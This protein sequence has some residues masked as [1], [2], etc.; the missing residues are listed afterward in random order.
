MSVCK[1]V[2]D[3]VDLV[4]IGRKRFCQCTAACANGFAFPKI[5]CR[6]RYPVASYACGCERGTCAHS[7]PLEAQREAVDDVCYGNDCACN[8]PGETECAPLPTV[9][10]QARGY[11]HV[12]PSG[13]GA[14]KDDAKRK[15]FLKHLGATVRDRARAI[16]NDGP[17]VALDIIT[18]FGPLLACL[19][20]IRYL[21]T[22]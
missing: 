16:S 14:L 18:F 3:H 22:Q 9:E 11:Y 10:A 15:T 13:R 4:T 7:D 20:A 19:L 2:A 1:A 6:E 17:N 5:A 12:T 8:L 21:V